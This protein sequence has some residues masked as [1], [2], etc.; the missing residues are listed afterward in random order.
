M[1]DICLVEMSMDEFTKCW[2]NPCKEQKET[3]ER[4]TKM[5]RKLQGERKRLKNKV[6]RLKN[7]IS[8]LKTKNESSEN[9][10]DE[11]EDAYYES[12]TVKDEEFIDE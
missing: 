3:I 1:T 12:D 6:G 4:Y 9:T 7:V 8:K 5:I 10:K 11:D 2:V